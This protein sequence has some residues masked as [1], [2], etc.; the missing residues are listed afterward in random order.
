VIPGA[1]VARD[2]AGMEALA[3]RTLSRGIIYSAA[4][5]RYL[6][7]AIQSAISSYRFNKIPHLIFCDVVPESKPDGVSYVKF[8]RGGNPYADKI[9]NM[10]ASPFDATIFLDS[11]TYVCDSI[12]EL[13]DLMPRFD[14]A[15]AHAPGYTKCNDP[16]A[17]AFYDFNT[18]VVVFNRTEATL[19][20]LRRWLET[21]EKWMTDPP[22]KGAGSP[23]GF[24]DQPAFRRCVLESEVAVYTLP[25]EYNYRTVFP[26]RLV[27]SAKILHGRAADYEA[28]VRILNEQI[29]VRTFA[30]FEKGWSPDGAASSAPT[31]SSPAKR[32]RRLKWPFI[33]AIA[34]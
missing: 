15:A 1:H 33:G 26:G 20:L 8:E 28:L 22:F 7:E 11:D 23:N 2:A 24:A 30:A 21:Y 27:G 10:I 13:F 34:K 14:I 12:E 9:C 31:N 16:M 25:P 17:P 18:G 6:K 29:C 4:G 19:T 3:T 5:E 32:K